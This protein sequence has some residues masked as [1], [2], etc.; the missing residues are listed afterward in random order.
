[1]VSSLNPPFFPFTGVTCSRSLGR[2]KRNG[3]GVGDVQRVVSVFR[4][5]TR[6]PQIHGRV[7]VSTVAHTGGCFSFRGLT[8]IRLGL[9]TEVLSLDNRVRS[10]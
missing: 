8:Y 4:R 1:M 2:S 6:D 10:R 5:Y 3:T 9:I 7:S